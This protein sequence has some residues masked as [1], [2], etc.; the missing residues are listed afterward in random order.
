[1]WSEPRPEARDYMADH[2]SV[3]RQRGKG[4]PFMQQGTKRSKHMATTLPVKK[5]E[6]IFDELNK[7]HDR[8]MKRA[9]EIFDGNGHAFGKDLEDWLR[10]ENELVWKPAIEIEEKDK[11]IL[12]RMATPGVDPKDIDIEVTPEDILVRA[13]THHEHKE[14][15]GKVHVCEFTSGSLFRSV[16]LPKKINPDRVKAE[17]KNG[18]L[19]LTAEIVKQAQPHKIAAKAS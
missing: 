4:F 13:E 3:V 6:S 5:K 17:F 7:M 10:A 18:I 12:L 1:M 15:K 19:S 16:H 11:E 8:I 14:E 2:A 9:F